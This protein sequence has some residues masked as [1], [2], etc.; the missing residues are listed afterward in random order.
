MKIIDI[1]MA[2]NVFKEPNKDDELGIDNYWDLIVYNANLTNSNNIVVEAIRQWSV[3]LL[4]IGVPVLFVLSIRELH[5]A[6]K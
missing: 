4:S 5:K 1:F 2:A 6:Q 3:L